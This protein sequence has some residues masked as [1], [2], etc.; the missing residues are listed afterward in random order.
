MRTRARPVSTRWREPVTVRAPPRKVSSM[1][2]IVTHAPIAAR[3]SWH[4]GRMT[5]ERALR[6]LE[7]AYLEAR[8]RTTGSTSPGH[9]RAR[10]HDG[11]RGRRGGR[12]GGGARRSRPSAADALRPDD[13]RAV[14]T[15]REGL[16]AGGELLAARHRGGRR[17]GTRPGRVHP[18][19][20]RARCGF[21]ATGGAL[22]LDGR[23][24]TRLQVLAML[25]TR[26][27][28]PRAGARCSSRSSRCGG[29]ST[30]TAD[31][32]RRTG[33]S[34]QPRR[35]A[36]AARAAPRSTERAGAGRHRRRHRD[37]GHDR[38]RGLAHGGRRA[39]ARPRRAA[40]RAMGLVVAGRRGASPGQ[41]RRSRSTRWSRSTPRSTPRSART[42]RRSGSCS[43]SATRAGRP[44]VP[45]AFT[46][47][48]ERPHQ[49]PDGTW[50][51][52]RPMI[53]ESLTGGGLG[54]LAELVHETGHAIHI[55]GI[56]TR[57][58]FTDWPDSDALTEALGD[59]VGGQR[60]RPGLAAPLAP[61]RR[62]GIGRGRAAA[63]AYAGTRSMPRGRLFEMRLHET[64]TAP[65]RRVDGDHLDVARD[66]APP[67]VVVVGDPRPARPGARVH[68]ELRDRGRARGRPPGADP[69]GARRLA[70]RRPGLVRVGARAPSTGSGWSGRRATCCADVPRR[71]ADGGAA[72]SP[73]SRVAAADGPPGTIERVTRPA[74]SRPVRSVRRARIALGSPRVIVPRLPGPRRSGSIAV[75]HRDRDHGPRRTWASGRGRRSTRASRSS[76]ALQLGTV[77]ILLGIPILLAWWPAG[78]A[79]GRRDGHQHRAHRDSRPTS[80]S[81]SCRRSRAQPQQLAGDAAPAS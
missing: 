17:R 60:P 16:A 59:L 67:R 57:P 32:D 35:R 61:G 14:A 13:G 25:G 77:S 22:T 48:G 30:A 37:L 62:R 23:P 74:P 33:R 18:S 36:L 5:A 65:E 80:L 56:R 63:A 43:T 78:R 24:L 55:A 7:A 50:D 70:G 6:G 4:H 3:G 31:A 8:R 11:A 75:R 38:A 19:R 64:R 46:T 51:P 26:S 54:E 49:R 47:F 44:P 81:A 42:S 76:P 10:R 68:G 69:R 66:R 21:A 40:G 1:A 15:M 29:A 58:A 71:A 73:S 34:S 12:D 52:G 20:A 45:V 72:A 79:A 53:L 27:P 2:P 28:T 41:R 39:R 9:R